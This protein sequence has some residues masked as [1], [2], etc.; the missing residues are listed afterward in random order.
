MMNFKVIANVYKRVSYKMIMIMENEIRK[1]ADVSPINIKSII[2][3][4]KLA[5]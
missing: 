5:K 1:I 3:D 2:L 4:A